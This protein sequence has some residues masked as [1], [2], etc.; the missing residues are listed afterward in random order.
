[1]QKKKRA[2][3]HSIDDIE[4]ANS[5]VNAPDP[6][7]RQE[8]RAIFLRTIRDIRP[9]VLNSLFQDVWPIHRAL[10]RPH[11]GM[12][13]NKAL[14]KQSQDTISFDPQASHW[15]NYPFWNWGLFI[16]FKWSRLNSSSLM[17]V[18][19]GECSNTC[20]PFEYQ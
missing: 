2:S 8:A 15:Y 10:F 13:V 12:P 7:T 6:H 9:D 11:Q 19:A 17:V 1:M 20:Q 18:Q 16:D 3:N 4:L 5:C 14:L